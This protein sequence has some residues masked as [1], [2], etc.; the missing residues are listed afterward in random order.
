MGEAQEY[1]VYFCEAG[2]LILTNPSAGAIQMT[3]RPSS[4]EI[5]SFVPIK[6]LG[7]RGKK[8]APIG[9]TNMFNSGGTVQ[10]LKYK[11]SSVEIEVKGGG[12]FLAYSSAAPKKCSLNGAENT[13][14][15]WS[16]DDGKLELNIVWNEQAHGISHLTL[17]F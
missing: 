16:G 10:G 7:G 2:K 3:I 14:F 13:G 1:A 4:F 9:F 11:E 6:E 5:C 12:S 8:F 15:K 17:V